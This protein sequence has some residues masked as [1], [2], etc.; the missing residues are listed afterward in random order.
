MNL[1]VAILLCF[2][3]AASFIAFT[4]YM[5][6]PQL[7]KEQLERDRLAKIQK[8]S[9][10]K[11]VRQR[12]LYVPKRSV[13]LAQEVL[14]KLL[15]KRPIDF[16]SNDFSLNLDNNKKDELNVKKQVLTN[17][18]DT[19]NNLKENAVLSITTYTDTNGSAEANLLL[20]Q[21]RADKLKTY[22]LERTNLLFITAIGYGEAL[23]LTSRRVEINLKK[24]Q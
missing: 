2:I 15:E 20:S 23:P 17:I 12:K 24:V 4:L 7:Y 13:L 16:T 18:V 3:V 10:K 5:N 19:V 8:T 21:K 1:R 14:N 6:A 11:Y 22:F 9:A